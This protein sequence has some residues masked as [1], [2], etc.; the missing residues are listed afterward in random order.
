MKRGTCIHF[1]GLRIGAIGSDCCAAGINYRK[2]F[3]DSQPG[4]MLRMPCVAFRELQADR[5]GSMIRPGDATVRVEIDR[6]GNAVKPC[7]HRQEPTDV[8]IEKHQRDQDAGFQKVIAALQVASAWRVNPKPVQDR[9][10]VVDCP[11][12]NGRLHLHQSAYNGHCSGKCETEGCVS[13]ME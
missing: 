2:T 7:L 13:W 11:V 3:D 8:Q 6:K 1:T 4:I 12:C 9:Q 5:R 10:E